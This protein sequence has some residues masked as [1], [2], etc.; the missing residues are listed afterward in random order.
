MPIKES[1]PRFSPRRWLAALALSLALGACAPMPSATVADPLP[2][3][4]AGTAKQRIVHFVKAVNTEGG[5]DYVVHSC[6]SPDRRKSAA[7]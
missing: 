6:A 3:W 1:I 5:K 7:R 4:N 2:S